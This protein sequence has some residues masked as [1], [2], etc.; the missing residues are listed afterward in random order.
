[1]NYYEVYSQY[2]GKTFDEKSEDI[3]SAI[4]TDNVSIS[5]FSALLSASAEKYLEEIAARAHELTISNFGKTIQ[6][7]TPMYLSDYCENKCA[8]CGF[9]ADNSFKRKKLSLDEV[10]KEAKFIASTGLKHI[11][12]LTGESRKMTP[13]SYIKDCVN[14]LKKYFSSISIEIFPLTEAEYAELVSCGV[15]GLTIYQEVYD[16]T[17]YDSVHLA[18]AKKNYNFRLDAPERGCA[19]GMRNVNIGILLGLAP[20]RKEAFFMGLH[21]KYLQDKFPDVEIGISLPRLRPQVGNFTAP[22]IVTDKNIVQMIMALRL[23]LPRVGI[24]ISTRENPEF[25]EN[26]LSLGITKMSAGSTTAV[27][28]HTLNQGAHQAQFRISDERSVDEIKD[29]IERKGYQPVLKDWLQ[30]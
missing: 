7:Y 20:W 9:T 27:G 26:I 3:K 11:L 5:Q 24:T 21:A 29:A 6:L 1:M 8:Y 25:R 2:K 14:V 18:G 17:V 10:E 22:Y 28:G 4:L 12:I 23:F 13:I 15:D 19:S 30:L 16:E